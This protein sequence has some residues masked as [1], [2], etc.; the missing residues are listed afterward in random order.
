MFDPSNGD[1]IGPFVN[2][3]LTFGPPD[4]LPGQWAMPGVNQMNNHFVFY[5]SSLYGNSCELFS[6]IHF[7]SLQFTSIYADSLQDC[8]WGQPCDDGSLWVAYGLPMGSCTMTTPSTSSH[9]CAPH[10]GSCRAMIH[11]ISPY[12]NGSLGSDLGRQPSNRSWRDPIWCRNRRACSLRP[13]HVALITEVKQRRAQLVLG[14]VTENLLAVDPSRKEAAKHQ[15]PS[16]CRPNMLVWS[17]LRLH[18]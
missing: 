2:L 9:G 5:P 8:P 4:V 12:D 10:G 1:L 14:W 6:Q 15:K 18:H 7:K 3:L 13:Y 11:G 17:S 16:K